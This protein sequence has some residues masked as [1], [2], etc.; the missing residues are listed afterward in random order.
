MDLSY[1][2]LSL[3]GR[4]GRAR[5]WLGTVV[6]AG[7]SMAATYLIVALVG[8]SQAAGAFSAAVAVAFALAYPSYAIMAK[9]FQD[10]DK[11]GLLALLLLIPSYGAN[12]L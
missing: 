1:L 10:R 8:I 6:V 9:R 4:I 11:P 3:D 7:V 12:L 5:F 2:F